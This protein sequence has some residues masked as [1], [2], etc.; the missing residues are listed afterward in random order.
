MIQLKETSGHQDILKRFRCFIQE[1]KLAHAYLFVGPQDIGKSETALG[2][3]KLVNCEQST[4]NG[5]CDVCPSCVKI[6]RGNHPDVHV[7]SSEDALKIKIDQVRQLLKE[8][9]LKPFEAKRK[10]FIIKSIDQLTLEGANALLK[11]LEE[12]SD[13][14]LLLSTTTFPDKV[15]ST[16]KSRC[17]VINFFPLS[18]RQLKDQL[19]N[20]YQL[21]EASSHFLATFAQGCSKRALI[22]YD[23]KFLEK[24]NTMIDHFIFA[25]LSETFARDFLAGQEKEDI[26]ETLN[27]LLSWFRDILL[28]K[29]HI[30]KTQLIHQDRIDDLIRSE[31]KYS[32]DQTERTLHDLVATSKLLKE[33]L[34]VKM[35]LTLLKERI[36]QN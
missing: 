34:N 11:T 9:Q 26:Q 36:W 13:R 15:L 18:C 14:S 32:W 20:D 16:I 4:S 33:N 28:L 1:Q 2:V 29:L 24:K 8:I 7:I 19:R 3:A 25:P 35:A 6:N 30:H 10:V 21:S 5:Y 27:V 31:K 23:Q 12:P 17:Q 22:L